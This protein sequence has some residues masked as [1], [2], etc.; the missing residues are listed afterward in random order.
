MAVPVNNMPIIMAH[1]TLQ[2]Q[3][4]SMHAQQMAAA[5]NRIINQIAEEEKKIKEK[6]AEE[7]Y[8]P[9]HASKEDIETEQVSF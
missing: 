3:M 1:M 4:A 2:N 6:Q 9:K 7:K 5:R 8:I